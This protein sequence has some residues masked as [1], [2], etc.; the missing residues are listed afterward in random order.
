MTATARQILPA[1]ADGT[2]QWKD[3]RTAGFG[4]TNAADLFLGTTS[5]FR[6]WREKRGLASK[7]EVSPAL[8]ALFDH[9]HER[10]KPL[11]DRFTRE[12]GLKVRNTGTWARKDRPW[13]LANPDRL[14]GTDGL[15]EIKTTGGRAEA[16]DW[17]T[18]GRVHPKAW[19]QAHWYAYVTGRTVLWFI[20]EVDRVPFILGPYDADQ[21]L[22]ETLADLAADFWATVQDG[23]APDDTPEPS[24]EIAYVPP[25]DGTEVVIDPW[26]DL[27]ETVQGLATLK[28]D[29]KYIAEEVKAA[30]A[31]VQ[32]AMGGAEVL[33]S[34]DGTQLVTWKPTKPRTSLDKDAMRAD[35]INPDDYMKAGKPGRQ[36][37]VK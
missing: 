29:A 30:E 5:R 18:S 6:L 23:S 34:R 16:V 27:S 33:R 31:I 26:D 32:E 20:A 13:A 7:E 21:G 9:G 10:E 37:L 22:I 36:F 15:L 19:V 28:A 17:W 24:R 4:G 3:Q 35:G 2:E 12:T 11:A 25:A 1:A 8:Q 14:V